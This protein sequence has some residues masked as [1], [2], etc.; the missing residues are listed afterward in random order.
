MATTKSQVLI[1]FPAFLALTF[2]ADRVWFRCANW[3]AFVLPLLPVG[4]SVGLWYAVQWLGAGPALFQDNTAVLREGSAL[5][6]LAFDPANWRRV[7][8]VVWRTGFGAWGVAALVWAWVVALRRR[9]VEGLS[10]FA[11]AS[12][13]TAAV[14]WFAVLSIGWGRYAF[15]AMTLTLLLLAGFL[16]NL[17]R[18]VAPDSLAR[19]WLT[20]ASAVFALVFAGFNVLGPESAVQN[21]FNARDSGYEAMSRYLAEAL[22]PEVIVETWE[23]EFGVLPAPRMRHPPTRTTNW[24]TGQIMGVPLNREDAYR[25][26]PQGVCYVLVGQF[27]AWTGLYSPWTTN[28]ENLKISFGHYQLWHVDGCGQ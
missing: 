10:L 25:P 28:R 2:L 16:G 21:L 7:L 12:F 8:G 22:P 11:V 27:G 5:H 24:Y 13:A 14:I 17:P 20:L 26:V 3:R 23:W 15:Y 9:S 6:V 19:H 4:A 1:L 18:L